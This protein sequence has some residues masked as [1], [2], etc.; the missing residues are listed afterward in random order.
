MLPSKSTSFL[1]SLREFKRIY[2]VGHMRPD[3]DCITSQ[4]GIKH[5]CL[6]LGLEAYCWNEGP[7]NRKESSPYKDS[8]LSLSAL[9]RDTENSALCLVDCSTLP[10]AGKIP[11]WLAQLPLFV[12]DHHQSEDIADDDPHIICDPDS[13]A[14]VALVFELLQAAQCPIDTDLA[15]LLF[16]GIA[17]D[18]YFFRYVEPHQYNIFAITARLLQ[19]GASPRKGAD[20]LEITSSYEAMRLIGALIE[21]MRPIENTPFV[22]TY[23]TLEEKQKAGPIESSLLYE[24]ML[25]TEPHKALLFAWEES[26]SIIVGNLRAKAP[27]SILDIATRFGGGGHAQAAG[28]RQKNTSL[29]TVLKQ[30][31]EHIQKVFVK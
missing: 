25:R 2:I 24:A 31:K 1:S 3:A 21:R 20:E 14:A 17:S 18:T 8:F 23:M 12:V 7:F 19:S 22:Y 30:T 13:P 28:F 29:H 5:L 11:L 10:R 16:L 9:P 6:F 26:S 27:L 15:Q 4:L